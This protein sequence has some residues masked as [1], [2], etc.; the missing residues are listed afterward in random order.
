MDMK[1]KFFKK[2]IIEKKPERKTQIGKETEIKIKKRVW[3][4]KGEKRQ[5]EERCKERNN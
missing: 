2:E 4:E 5:K 1:K 3:I